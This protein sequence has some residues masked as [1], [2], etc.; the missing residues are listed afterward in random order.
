M[1][2]RI[3]AGLLAAALL[4]SGCSALLTREY[5]HV[6]PH[7]TAPTAEGAPYTLRAESYQELVNAL[8]YFVSTGVE[9]GTVR[10][11]L[12]FSE[13][14][15]DLEAACFEVAQE[16]PLGAYAVEFMKYSVDPVVTYAEANI[17]ITYRRTR[18][19]VAS[20]VT[21]TGITAIRGELESALSSFATERVLRVSYFNE[22]EAFIQSLAKQAYYNVPAVALGMPEISVSI[23]PDT[24]RQR[25]VEVLLTYPE[26]IAQLEEKKEQLAQELQRLSLSVLGFSEDAPVA[27]ARLILM[28]G[29]YD[30]E[31]G[32][33]AYHA[34]LTGSA[35]SEGLALAYA[36]LCEVLDIPCQVVEGTRG[37]EPQF[38]NLVSCADGWR[39]VDLTRSRL[40]D[41][42]LYTDQEMTELGYLWDTASAPQ[43]VQTGTGTF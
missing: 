40:S 29:T 14:E 1:K 4:L 21:A 37:E 11:Y 20:I 17:Q 42:L 32:S 15:P 9:E 2:T 7:S 34:L 38:W 13:V 25:I 27:A 41:I 35:D 3:L 24:G 36:A 18:E 28:A 23:Y 26:E 12:D 10:L 16:D 30:P 19:Q 31:G 6:T 39:H 43:A 8:Q 22:D 33:T 5:V